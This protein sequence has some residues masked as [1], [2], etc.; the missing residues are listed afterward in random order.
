MTKNVNMEAPERQKSLLFRIGQ[1][2]FFVILAVVFFLLAQSMV[3]HRFHRGG[4]LN[5]NDTLRP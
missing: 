1:L 2:L 3:H 5:Q 4:W